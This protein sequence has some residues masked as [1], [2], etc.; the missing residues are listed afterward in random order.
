MTMTT[1]T[2]TIT[3]MCLTIIKNRYWFLLG[4]TWL[5]H[6]SVWLISSYLHCT[7]IYNITLP[8]SSP[9]LLVMSPSRDSPKK[10]TP[11]FNFLKKREP[12]AIHTSSNTTLTL[13]RNPIRWNK[14]L[15]LWFWFYFFERWNPNLTLKPWHTCSPLSLSSLQCRILSHQLLTTVQSAVSLALFDALVA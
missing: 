8:L 6:L 11:N 1:T 5:Y 7:S 3:T 2:M 12:L 15:P 9:S 14:T 4:L 10:S 13:T